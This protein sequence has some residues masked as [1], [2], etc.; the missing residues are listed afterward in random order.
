MCHTGCRT[1]WSAPHVLAFDRPAAEA[2]YAELADVVKP[3]HQAR[4]ATDAAG[5][6]IDEIVALCRDCQVPDT[7]AAVGIAEKDL[8]KLAEDAMEADPA[9]GEQP[10]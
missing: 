4:S 5:V 3:G 7:L 9:A 1:R 2:L 10:A 8:P 6:F